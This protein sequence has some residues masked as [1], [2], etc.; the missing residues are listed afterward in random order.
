MLHHQFHGVTKCYRPLTM[1]SCHRARTNREIP[2]SLI[3]LA[4]VTEIVHNV[5]LIIDDIVDESPTRRSKSTLHT[6][7]D[8]TTALSVASYLIAE[9][10]RLLSSNF[11]EDVLTARDLPRSIDGSF[12][13]DTKNSPYPDDPNA[14]DHTV[15]S[16]LDCD[17]ALAQ[18][19]KQEIER[20]GNSYSEMQLVSELYRR[21]AVAEVVQWENRKEGTERE[22]SRGVAMPPSGF[23]LK[24]W[25][26]LAREDTGSMF[27]ICASLGGRS[28]Q[29]RRFGRLLGMLYHASDDVADLE[30]ATEINTTPAAQTTVA[31]SGQLGGGGDQDVRD[32]ILT[33]PAALML[34]D[35]SSPPIH[36]EIFR[37]LDANGVRQGKPE[38]IDDYN[39]LLQALKSQTKAAQDELRNIREQLDEHIAELATQQIIIN[40]KP[41]CDLVKH[42]SGLVQR[43][44]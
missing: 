34:G 13:F 1:F 4:L 5:T 10:Y 30:N 26:F 16:P 9:S 8:E 28:Q 42:V 24:D 17:G 7:Y 41:L 32:G 40:P 11:S 33:L 3:S 31:R 15:G 14:V 21:L 18:L 25:R 19:S 23:G 44:G 35:K 39:A 36:R 29:L 12:A 37:R 6:M 38:A 27:E 20:N 2:D 43:P 22:R